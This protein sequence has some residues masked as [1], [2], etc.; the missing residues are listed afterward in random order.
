MPIS[1][2]VAVVAADAVD[3][4]EELK[5]A[6]IGQKRGI[7]VELGPIHRSMRD[8]VVDTAAVQV[9][10]SLDMLATGR[11]DSQVP[12]RGACDEGKGCGEYG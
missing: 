5:G 8:I 1:T 9:A 11:V 3:T 7:R 12:S 6:W 2:T 10:V 4:R